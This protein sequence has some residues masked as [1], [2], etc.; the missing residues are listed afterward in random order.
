MNEFLILL[1]RKKCLQIRSV[2][3]VVSVDMFGDAR[4][5]MSALRLSLFRCDYYV[6]EIVSTN[7]VTA[8]V[9]GSVL[10]RYMPV[11]SVEDMFI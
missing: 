3:R 11:S 2:F 10:H 5:E 7:V 8:Q 4:R 1:D 9:D 6:N